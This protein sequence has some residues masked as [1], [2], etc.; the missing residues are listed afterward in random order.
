MER[1]AVRSSVCYSRTKPDDARTGA[2]GKIF[3]DS[4]TDHIQPNQRRWVYVGGSC[5]IDPTLQ[6]QMFQHT[7]GVG[8]D[9]DV[10]MLCASTWGEWKAAAQ[11]LTAGKGTAFP[12]GK[13]MDDFKYDVPSVL[14]FHELSHSREFMKGAPIRNSKTLY[15]HTFGIP[16]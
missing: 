1:Q 9:V 10:M 13:D 8:G 5:K 14:L 3:W 12:D 4:R 7:S 15:R 6:G 16:V 11:T 2:P